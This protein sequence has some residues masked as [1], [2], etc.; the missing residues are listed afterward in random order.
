MMQPVD[1][2]WH[3]VTGELRMSRRTKKSVT[4]Y[5]YMLLESDDA[6]R[7]LWLR[8]LVQVKLPI[9]SIV[10]SG[11]R[12]LH[13]LV[14]LGCNTLDEWQELSSVCRDVM[15]R[16]GCDSQA[17]SNPMAS[18]RAPHVMREGKMKDGKFAPFTHPAKQR[19]LWLNP[20]ASARPMR[21]VLPH[22]L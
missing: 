3:P 6:P 19:L 13:A 17:L 18:P 12:S 2:Q 22:G 15:S 5:P 8:A 1:G 20:N 11:G 4:R 16:I 10:S 9:V 21:E 7:E 14:K